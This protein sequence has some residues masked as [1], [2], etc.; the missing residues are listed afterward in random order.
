VLKPVKDASLVITPP[1]TYL[2]RLLLKESLV[3]I[4]NLIDK[5][6]RNRTHYRDPAYNE[7]QLR[8]DFLDPLFTLLVGL[9]L[10]VLV[11]GMMDSV[12]RTVLR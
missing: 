9:K 3:T 10:L 11:L 4:Q 5:Y 12:D 2:R 1:L 7:A 8:T 6:E